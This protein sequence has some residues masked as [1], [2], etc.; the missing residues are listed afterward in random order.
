MEISVIVA[1]LV[2]ILGWIVPAFIKDTLNKRFVGMV[3]SSFATGIF[4][5]ILLTIIF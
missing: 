2:L 3:L 4:I 1:W 5:G